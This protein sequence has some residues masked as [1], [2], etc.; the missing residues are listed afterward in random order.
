MQSCSTRCKPRAPRRAPQAEE[1]G[2]GDEEDEAEEGGSEDQGNVLLRGA[3][4]QSAGSQTD[5]EL[6]FDDSTRGQEWPSDSRTGVDMLARLAAAMLDQQQ[7]AQ[8]D[9]VSA[10][11]ACWLSCCGYVCRG[12]GRTGATACPRPPLTV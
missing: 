3:A 4:T 12:T 8:A 1:E 5:N 9:E 10:A 6:Y 7:H 2:E 11:R